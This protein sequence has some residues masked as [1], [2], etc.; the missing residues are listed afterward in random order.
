MKAMREPIKI[1]GAALACLAVLVLGAAG[2]PAADRSGFET[3]VVRPGDTLSGI[4][5]RVLGDPSRWREILRENPQVKNA[6]RIYPGDSLLVPVPQTAGGAGGAAGEGGM[7]AGA[8]GAGAGLQAAPGTDTGFADGSS[9][10]AA[11]REAAAAEAAAAEAAAAAAAADAAAAAAAAAAA[12]KAATEALP[13]EVVRSVPVVPAG[14][15]RSAGYLADG[16]PLIAIIASE[17]GKIALGPGDA[18]I[19]NASASAGARFAV[20]RAD[21]RIFHPVTRRPLGWLIRPLGTAEVTCGDDRN[22]TA[23]LGSMRDAATIGDYLVPLEEGEPE[24]ALLARRGSAQ[25]VAPGEGEGMII[26]F[27]EEKTTAGEREIAY[28]D[29]GSD[30]G[31]EAGARFVIYRP[32]RP[33]GQVM[34]GELQVLKVGRWSATA[35][36]TTSLREVQVADLL[37]AK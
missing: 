18:V 25:C 29:R 9:A 21:R 32:L 2:L 15:L 27:D 10:D 11:A 33:V 1:V 35:L 26:A 7:G 16:L 4:A 12:D 24:E 6:N 22:A 30:A 20:L 34:V 13:V 23:V 37:R 36:I 31:V 3:Y 14:V 17:Q 8:G 19:L 5:G 28:I